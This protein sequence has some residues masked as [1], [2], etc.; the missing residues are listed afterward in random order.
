MANI[1]PPDEVDRAHIVGMS[2]A[3]TLR[4]KLWGV[5]RDQIE[6]Y[7]VEVEAKETL[8]TLD[9]H[10]AELGLSQEVCGLLERHRNVRTIGE[11][12]NLTPLSLESVPWIGKQRVAEILDRARKFAERENEIEGLADAG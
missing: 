12:L 11:L 5:A 4:N 8:S 6:A 10:V 1:I 3:F 7:R 9:S 2:I